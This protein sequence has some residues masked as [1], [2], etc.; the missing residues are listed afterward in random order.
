VNVKHRIPVLAAAVVSLLALTAGGALAT[1]PTGTLDASQTELTSTFPPSTDH[2]LAQTFTA[3]LTG[4]LD[5]VQIHTTQLVT[6][7]LSVN[8]NLSPG[9]MTVEIRTTDGSG[10]PT[11]TVLATQSLTPVHADWSNVAFNTQAD[12]VTG[13]KY[14]IVVTEVASVGNSVNSWD[15]SCNDN[16]GPGAALVLNGAVWMTVPAYAAGGNPEIDCMQDFAFRTFVTVAA[17]APVVTP[18]PTPVVTPPPT[19]APTAPP[20]AAPTLAPTPPP[21][22]TGGSTS[23]DSPSNLSYLLAFAGFASVAVAV[24]FASNRR[25]RLIRR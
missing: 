18:P 5:T 25:R 9:D 3:T 6:L 21:T 22:S 19:L 12:V 4:K 10:L 8:P 17:P 1:V 16:Y 24:A 23:G 7:G 11:S 13:T 15:G 14:A 2:P 20:T